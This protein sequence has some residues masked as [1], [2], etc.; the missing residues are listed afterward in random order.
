LSTDLCKSESSHKEESRA[1]SAD[2]FKTY[3]KPRDFNC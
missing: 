2:S 3:S 1:L